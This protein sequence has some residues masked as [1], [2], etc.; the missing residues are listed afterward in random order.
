M[1][2][3]F[4]TGRFE[5]ADTDRVRIDRGFYLFG[6]DFFTARA[7]LGGDA[8]AVGRWSAD[9]TPPPTAPGHDAARRIGAGDTQTVS[10]PMLGTGQR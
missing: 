6:D 1:S 7:F 10:P 5:L 2:G 4:E 8:G 3:A 9:L